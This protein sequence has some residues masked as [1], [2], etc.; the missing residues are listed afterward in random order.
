[1]NE[2]V[3]EFIDERELYSP[4]ANVRRSVMADFYKWVEDGRLE[5]YKEGEEE[6]CMTVRAKVVRRLWRKKSKEELKQRL[7]D[8]KVS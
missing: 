2:Y 8:A 4:Y 1:M 7:E 5:F 3:V 6:A